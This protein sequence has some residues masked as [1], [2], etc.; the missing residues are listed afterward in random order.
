VASPE[1]EQSLLHVALAGTC[2]HVERFVRACRRVDRVAE[3]R[4]AAT[5]HLNRQLST[6]V[7]DDGMV[8][9][10]GRLTPEVGAVVQRALEAAADRLFRDAA[11]AP[12]GDA[13]SEALT[14]AQRRAD[15]LA[16]LAETALHPS[17]QTTRAGGP[18]LA[19]GLDGGTA[20]DRYQ[21]VLH[22]NADAPADDPVEAPAAAAADTF[23]G[24]LEVDHGALYVS[25]ETSRRLACDASLVRMRHDSEGD[26]LDVGRKTRTIP[27]AI[28]RALTARDTTCRFPGC[29]SRRC[30]CHHVHHWADGGA[31][32]L[33]N[34]VRLCRRHHRAVHEGGF[35]VVRGLDG[36]LTFLRPDGAPQPVVPAAPS[37]VPGWHH[38]LPLVPGRLPTWDG[39]RFDVVWA[40]DVM[41]SNRPVS[42]LPA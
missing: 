5:R 12:T 30:D 7:D 36:G 11:H 24:A 31:T 15:A 4:Q 23:E 14:P 3:V 19:G 9:I 32:R 1:N 10:R 2:A 33:D 37:N 41:R 26:N 29:T 39:T 13:M 17:A 27:P 25:M 42:T 20:G 8:V 38:A 22:V 28:R 18:G 34:L 21:V 16:L 6:W 40:I 35:G